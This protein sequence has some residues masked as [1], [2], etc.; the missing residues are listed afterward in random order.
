MAILEGGKIR[1]LGTP[2]EVY[3][4]PKSKFVANFMGET[5]F[6][7]GKVVSVETGML[8][9]STPLG[10]LTS[11]AELAVPVQPGQA[12]TVSLRPEVLRLG[13]AP[14]GSANSFRASV[15]HTLY[16]GEM[17][18]H[19]VTVAGSEMKAFEMNPRIVARDGNKVEAPLWISERDV[20][21]VST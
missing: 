18:Q 19:T 14:P 9:V 1:Q 21:V 13:D 7:D 12:V 10:E 2:Q 6:L 11:R 17:A 5:N 20:V 8:R 16:M 15:H 3:L 4:R